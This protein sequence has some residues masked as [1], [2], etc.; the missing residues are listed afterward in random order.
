M[1]KKINIS[2]FILQI[3]IL[4]GEGK[5]TPFDVLSNKIYIYTYT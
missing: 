4:M 3:K 1:Q 5:C 2:L